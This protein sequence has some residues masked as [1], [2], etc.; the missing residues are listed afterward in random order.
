MFCCSGIF[1]NHESE[2]R[3]DS[4]F[5]KKI[6]KGVATIKEDLASGTI[7]DKIAVGNLT[8]LRDYGYAPDFMEAV[9]LMMQ[10]QTPRDYVI[11]TGEL[12][13]MEDFVKKSF[14]YAGL[15]YRNFIYHD[16]TL[17]RKTD[18][19]TLCANISKI[20][21]ELGWKPAHKVEDI[22]RK[23]IDSEPKRQLV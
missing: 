20:K 14:E 23:M 10:A 9:Y 16:E 7:T 8:A 6:T 12:I 11:G 3:G 15:D 22:I 21:N 19:A 18:T 5:S 13:S 17:D 1:F 4:F 2:R